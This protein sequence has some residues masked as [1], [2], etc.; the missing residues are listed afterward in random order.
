[1]LT[2]TQM[3]VP[4]ERNARNGASINSRT[5]GT[6]HIHT[7][8]HA[9]VHFQLRQGALPRYHRH[10]H[11]THTCIHTY[12]HTFPAPTRGHLVSSY[13]VH[14]H[15]M[16]QTYVHTHT[17]TF[18]ASTRGHYLA[19]S[20]L[21]V[22]LTREGSISVYN[23]MLNLWFWYMRWSA[24]QSVCALMQYVYVFLCIPAC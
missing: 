2:Y 19:N 7:Y 20:I 1:M 11:F 6:V 16:I 8:I 22:P 24:G 23:C 4:L 9:C 5:F 14:I 21:H 18:S 3:L 10:I 17:H 13:L 15:T 12:I